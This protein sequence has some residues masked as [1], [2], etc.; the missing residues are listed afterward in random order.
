MA[1][2][3]SLWTRA[4]KPLGPPDFRRF[5]HASVPWVKAIGGEELAPT[6]TSAVPRWT[7]PPTWA[8][9]NAL[10]PARLSGLRQ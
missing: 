7:S 9:V 10:R 8:G 3:L 5:V 2:N 1:L 4:E 6:K